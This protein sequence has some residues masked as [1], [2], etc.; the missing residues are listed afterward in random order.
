MQRDSSSK[1]AE[2]KEHDIFSS[3]CSYFSLL[4]TQ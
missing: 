4:E 1:K 2:F 3:I